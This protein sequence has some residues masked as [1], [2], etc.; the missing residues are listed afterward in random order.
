MDIYKEL[1]E[2]SLK[3]KRGLTFFV[4][5]QTVSG[6]VTEILGDGA[7][8]AYNQTYSRIVIR[9]DSIDAVAIG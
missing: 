3:E 9:L 6:V 1:I 2:R 8:A 5:G 4:N 7:V